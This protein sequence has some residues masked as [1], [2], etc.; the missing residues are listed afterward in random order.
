MQTDEAIHCHR[1][2]LDELCA[3]SPSTSMVGKYLRNVSHGFIQQLASERRGESALTVFDDIHASIAKY[4]SPYPL[5]PLSTLPSPT[6]S[7]P[8]HHPSPVTSLI[9]EV[10]ESLPMM[11]TSAIRYTVGSVRSLQQAKRIMD[12][13]RQHG[14]TPM[15]SCTRY[16]SFTIFRAGL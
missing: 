16:V 12:H 13:Q 8:L 6:T 11:Y 10:R 3:K 9:V 1:I 5:A 4:S 7:A 15:W 2:A 14:I